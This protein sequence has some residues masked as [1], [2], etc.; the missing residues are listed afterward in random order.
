MRLLSVGTSISSSAIWDDPNTTKIDYVP[1]SIYFLLN[2]LTLE[3]E[4]ET[5][6]CLDTSRFEF[7]V[8]ELLKNLIKRYLA[9]LG[10]SHS[11]LSFQTC[12]HRR[13]LTTHLTIVG[14]LHIRCLWLYGVIV[15]YVNKYLVPGFVSMRCYLQIFK[16]KHCESSV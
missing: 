8:D 5:V 16:I 12:N 15:I 3:L 10:S 1:Y 4:N 2:K 11:Y 14:I 9:V 6:T 13:W 7:M